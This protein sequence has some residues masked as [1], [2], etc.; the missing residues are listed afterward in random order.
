[1]EKPKQKEWIK[2]ADLAKLFEN[3]FIVVKNITSSGCVVYT[4]EEKKVS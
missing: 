3:Q 1:M 4:F 2:L